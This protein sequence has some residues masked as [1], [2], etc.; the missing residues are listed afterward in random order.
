MAEKTE[1]EKWLE[2]K[3]AR[4]KKGPAHRKGK[5][6]SSFEVKEP[7]TAPKRR[8]AKT[9][10]PEEK[11]EKI[12]ARRAKQ[13][14]RAAKPR[15]KKEKTSEQKMIKK[16]DVAFSKLVHKLE[17]HDGTGTCWTCDAVLMLA[18]LQTG[19]MFSRK[20]MQIRWDLRNAHLQCNDCNVI[21]GG[22]YKVYRAKFIEVYGQEAY[23]QLEVD[24]DKPFTLN[25]DDLNARLKEI[26]AQL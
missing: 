14:E 23:D 7:K 8:V 17:E 6:S 10:S 15:K 16:L 9:I 18:L 20:F 1:F 2:K 25:L 4:T 26:Q 5:K 12:K 19:H 3:N 22:N 13:K 11:K 24:R 21:K